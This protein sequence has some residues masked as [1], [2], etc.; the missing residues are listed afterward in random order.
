VS[1]LSHKQSRFV[2]EYLVDGNATQAATR[3]GYSAKTAK[4]QGQRL[5]TKVDIAQAI[6]AG[7]KAANAK[8]ELT[9]DM[10]RNRLRQII[11]HDI[12]KLYD[13]A[14]NLKPVHELDD[15]TAAAV[16]S[17]EVQVERNKDGDAAK[18]IT[19][20]HR[21]KTV[22]VA[23]AVELG[24]RHFGLGREVHEHSGP[25]GAPLF[26]ELTDL[27]LARR[28]AFVFKKGAAEAERS[29]TTGADAPQKQ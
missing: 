18:T 15:D 7:Q 28:L 2:A 17:V 22:D 23:R 27:E 21:V 12:R 3:A 19:Q 14:G 13:A 6:A 10:V 8:A 26:P 4:S 11:Q 9:A 20:T 5:L 24:M 16:C 29:E 1:E 25:N